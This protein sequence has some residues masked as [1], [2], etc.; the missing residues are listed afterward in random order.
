[1][2]SVSKQE[3][4]FDLIVIDT[5]AAG[6]S[7]AEIAHGYGRSVAL[8][9]KDKIGGDCPN[10]ACVPTKDLLRSAKVYS[11]L[12][13]AKGFGLRAEGIGFDWREVVAREQWTIRHTGAASAEQNYKSEGI[14]LFKGVASFEDEHRICVDGQILRGDRIMI[15]TGSQPRRPHIEGMQRVK[16]VTHKEAIHLE[17]FPSSILIVGGGPVG[18]EFAQLF[19]TFG[20]H[21]RRLSHWRPSAVQRG[22]QVR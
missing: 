10:Y 14:A 5:G 21:A 7:A 9:E 22:L 3:Q 18:C 2:N 20:A 4:H 17:K 8:I 15:A 12:K 1:M 13:R 6:G 16:P 11:L 19:S